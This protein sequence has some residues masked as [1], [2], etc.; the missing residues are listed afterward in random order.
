MEAQGGGQRLYWG[1]SRGPWTVRAEGLLVSGCHWP[2]TLGLSVWKGLRMRMMS[3][4]DWPA[5]LVANCM[6]S[7]LVLLAISSSRTVP[8][9]VA[10]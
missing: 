4:P 7:S 1:C 5:S 6:I 10:E 3:R 9:T 2:C 8:F